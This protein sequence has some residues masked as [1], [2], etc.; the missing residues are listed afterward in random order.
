VPSPAGTLLFSIILLRSLFLKNLREYEKMGRQ[1]RESRCQGAG[2]RLCFSAKRRGLLLL[3]ALCLSSRVHAQVVSPQA[4]AA[5]V[6][7]HYNSLHSLSVHFTQKFDGM[8]MHRSE[9][10]VL[11]LKKPQ[12]MRWTYSTPAGKLFVLDGHNAYFYSPGDTEVPRVP[13][14][15]LDDLRSPLR[16]LLGHTQLEKELG[17]LRLAP[18]E[19]GSYVLMGVP[20]GMEQRIASVSITARA[21]GTIQSMRIEE[22]DGIVNTFLFSDEV[23]NAPAPDSAFLFQPPA[24]VHIVDG[25]P[26]V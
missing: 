15:K 20:K 4:F 23:P 11:L 14:K 6:D 24:G 12:K 17:S 7:R 1:K 21:D 26:P 16:F 10:G 8:G 3:A 13:V 22:T 25:A 2:H 18:A 9:S 19:N 5:V